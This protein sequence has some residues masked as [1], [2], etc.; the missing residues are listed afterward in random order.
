MH[1]RS[2]FNLLTQGSTFRAD[3][4][5]GSERAHI[6][7]GL[8]AYATPLTLNDAFHVLRRMSFAPT[9]S[10]AT[11]LVGKSATEAADAILGTGNEAASS[12][13]GAWVDIA[14]ENP[15]Y[16]DIISRGALEGKWNT[17]FA[18]LQLWWAEQMRSESGVL[19]EKLTLFWSGH[20][21]SE[22]TYDQGFIPPQA[23]YHQNVMLR[24]NR[25]SNF[26]N[27][28]ET[29]SLDCA[30]LLY[31]GG[32]L[33]VKGTA[34]ENY[35]REMM[36]LFSCG[37]GQY[38]EGDVKNAAR[39]LTGWKAAVFSDAPAKNGIFNSFF[40]PKDHDVQAKQFMAQTIAARADADNTEFQVRNE[41]VRG[42]INILFNYRS[43]AIANFISRKLYRY[44]VYSNPSASD[45]AV[46]AEMR[47][48]FQQNNYDVK[49][50]LRA[51]LSSAHFY[52]AANRGVQIKTPAEFAV[53]LARQLGVALPTNTASSSD[54][55]KAS[56]RTME[57]DLMDPPNVAGWPGYR[58]WV[59]TK[60]YPLRLKFGR[61]IITSM[62]DTDV[63][64]F[65]QQIADN[66]DV[67][68]FVDNLCAFLLPKDIVQKRKDAYVATL[69]AGGKDYEW[70]GIVSNAATCGVR[71][72]SLLSAMIKAPDFHLC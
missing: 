56:M 23:L 33:N 44:F 36:E 63:Q 13:P 65:V 46:I 72:R 45:D 31:L 14:D 27:F 35:A 68:K 22:Y 5:E 24:Q 48:I 21:T 28:L 50:L 20:F 6:A 3:Q 62:S 16:L 67:Y 34:N 4:P 55:T 18:Q 49:P 69:L 17:N 10:A 19:R 52:D 7:S 8:E 51:L 11:A 32:V 58:N 54:V 59:N 57:Q 47:G 37:I 39:V 1:R 70:N 41:E 29:V 71:I 64:K 40:E 15:A 12:T 66:N 53:G 9:M 60:S 38:T 61:D 43:D 25:L 26:K 2:F 42:I 30:M